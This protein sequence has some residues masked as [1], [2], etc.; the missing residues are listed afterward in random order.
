MARRVG[1]MHVNMRTGVQ[2]DGWD[3]LA[4]NLARSSKASERP[5]L[6]E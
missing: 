4:A 5:F 1:A 6:R 2:E 3:L